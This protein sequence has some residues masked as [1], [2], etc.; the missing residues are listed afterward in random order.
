MASR[1]QLL[2]FVIY[3]FFNISVGKHTI[4]FHCFMTKHNRS[5]MLIYMRIIAMRL[6]DVQFPREILRLYSSI[7]AWACVC[8]GGGGAYTRA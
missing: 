1:F 7:L 5:F 3:L 8:G 4:I 2:T 6:S